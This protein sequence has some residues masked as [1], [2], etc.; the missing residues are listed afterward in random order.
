[1]SKANYFMFKRITKNLNYIVIVEGKERHSRMF[2]GIFDT[3]NMR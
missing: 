2:K 1:M 3:T